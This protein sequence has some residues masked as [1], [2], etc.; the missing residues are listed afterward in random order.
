MSA[1]CLLDTNVWVYAAGSAPRGTISNIIMHILKTLETLNDI[2]AKCS[3]MDSDTRGR[4]R[5]LIA[6]IHEHYE[7]EQKE[8]GQQRAAHLK[9][10]KALRKLEKA[11][12]D[13]QA[14][15]AKVDA[16]LAKSKQ[17]PK[18]TVVPVPDPRE[19]FDGL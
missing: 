7:A 5:A 2:L 15:K 4:A 14:E 6:S 13:L 8:H 16:E 19:K 9:L 11:Y 12:N 1:E 18:A 10:Q 3:T 17:P